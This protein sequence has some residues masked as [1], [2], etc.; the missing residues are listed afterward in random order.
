[1]K[2]IA[3]ILIIIAIGL[4]ISGCGKTDNTPIPNNA[5]GAAINVVDDLTMEDTTTNPDIGTLDDIAVS[6]EL[7]Q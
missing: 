2:S 7:P 1:M 5:Q 4:V 3:I 6:E